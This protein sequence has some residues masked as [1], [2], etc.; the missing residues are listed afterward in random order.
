MQIGD[1]TVASF[2]YTLTND[3]GA[4]ID[5]STDRAPLTYLH[6]AGSIVPGLEKEL[7]GHQ[8]GDTFDVVVSPE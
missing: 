3:A 1:R 2:H 8:A 5:S 6:G 7:V 4:V